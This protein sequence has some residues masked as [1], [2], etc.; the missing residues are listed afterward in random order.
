[1]EV[2]D[3][4]NTSKRIPAEEKVAGIL[5]VQTPRGY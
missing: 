5:Y 2:E 4:T 1:M 3:T